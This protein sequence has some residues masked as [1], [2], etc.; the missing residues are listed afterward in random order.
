MRPDSCKLVLFLLAAMLLAASVVG[1]A[2]TN[3]SPAETGSMPTSQEPPLPEPVARV[4]RALR[5]P[6]SD[7]SVFVQAVDATAPLVTFNADTPRN[8]AS[9]MKIV[10]TYAALETL[11]PGYEWHTIVHLRGTLSNGRL[12]GDLVLQGGGDPWLTSERFWRLLRELR[13][14]GLQH[15]EGDLV[16][17]DA[18]FSIEPESPAAFDG[19]PYRTYNVAPDALLVNFKAARF[20]FRGDA[21]TGTVLVD[22]DPPLPNLTIANRLRLGDGPC[23]GYQRGIAFDMPGGIAAGLVNL[24]GTFPR[25]CGEYEMWRSVL[26]PHTFTLGVFQSLWAELGG[27]F[28]GTVRRAPAP[29][30]VPPFFTFPSISLAEAVRHVNKY[31]NNAMARALLLTMAAERKGPPGTVA[32]GRIVIDEWLA[33]KGIATGA[34]HIAN[35]AGLA[36]DARIDAGVLGRVLLAGW[37]SPYQ[38]ELIASLPIGGIDGTLRTRLADHSATG[39]MHMKTGR[40]EGAV[41]I[42][43]YLF[44]ESGRHYVVVALDNSKGAH[45]GTAREWQERMIEWTYAR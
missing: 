36:R 6:M 32:N 21:V 42:A 25:G 3:A 20:L 39:R 26:E 31:S 1:R 11:G 38:A 9:T 16:I 37:Q 30:G 12:I 41:A 4:L 23:D 24:S 17:D 33:G 15:I 14:R 10:T 7:V 44:A 22:V 34:L 18:Y 40:L 5:T 29:E 27:T 8:P 28:T 43:G 35:G 19:Q 13:A 45:R 2:G